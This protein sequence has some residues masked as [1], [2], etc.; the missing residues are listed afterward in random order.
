MKRVSRSLLIFQARSTN[1]NFNLLDTFG[2][3]EEIRNQRSTLPDG[4]PNTQLLTLLVDRI[5]ALETAASEKDKDFSKSLQA[6]LNH[7]K[8]Q[9]ETITTLWTHVRALDKFAMGVSH[10]TLTSISNAKLSYST[11]QQQWGSLLKSNW[12][13]RDS[14]SQWDL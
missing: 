4:S 10:Y 13:T 12:T 1:D 7:Q 6:V 5:A 8:K 3:L 11:V 14:T 9:D 2:S